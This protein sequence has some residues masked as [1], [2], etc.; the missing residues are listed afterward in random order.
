MCGEKFLYGLNLNVNLYLRKQPRSSG[1]E[2]KCWIKHKLVVITDKLLLTMATW[3][4]TLI[5]M[6]ERNYSQEKELVN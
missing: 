4:M 1:N 3:N 6:R 2:L 5:T